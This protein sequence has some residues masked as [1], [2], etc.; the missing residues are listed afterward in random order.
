MDRKSQ[1]LQK[2]IDKEQLTM[3]NSITKEVSA[4]RE[5]LMEMEFIDLEKKEDVPEFLYD[6]QEIEKKSTFQT[7]FQ[8]KGKSRL[9]KKIKNSMWD[10]PEWIWITFGIVLEVALILAG[11]FLCQEPLTTVLL[12]III[13]NAL[14]VCL[15]KAPL[16]LH[17]IVVFANVVLGIVFSMLLFMGVVSVI[18]IIGILFIYKQKG[19][20]GGL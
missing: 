6:G 5:P 18:Y 15:S 8:E 10:I 20:I 4:P 9:Q 11:I 7:G 2:K 19:I 1:E 16:W 17:G 12:I 14:A 13:E 3:E